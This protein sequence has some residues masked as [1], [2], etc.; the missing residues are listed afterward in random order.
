MCKKGP[1]LVVDRIKS[2]YFIIAYV[3]LSGCYHAHQIRGGATE[4]CLK[5][6]RDHTFN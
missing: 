3:T 5:L 1:L 6:S 4:N 2:L